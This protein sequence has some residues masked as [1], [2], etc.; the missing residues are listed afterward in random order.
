MKRIAAILSVL[1]VISLYYTLHFYRQTKVYNEDK[2]AR[3]KSDE[4]NIAGFDSTKKSRAAVYMQLK[5]DSTDIVFLGN[6]LTEAFPVTDYFQNIHVKNRGVGGYTT[7]E[8]LEFLPE[9]IK[10]HPRKIFIE[11]GIN[12]I[13]YGLSDKAKTETD[14]IDNYN[15]ILNAIQ[16]ESPKTE[17]FIQ[18]ILPI[19]KIY[20]A[21]ESDTINAIVKI[22]NPQIRD[23][24]LKYKYNVIDLY[25]QF[26]D[27]NS[28]PL[29]YTTDGIHLNA[30]GYA[31][32]YETI[33]NNVN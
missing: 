7:A 20:N 14:L 30:N 27:N 23:L 1:L 17:V 8:V 16:I 22:L 2:L 24:G 5:I 9:I 25:A 19:N 18:N 11:I 33:K 32:W 13:K 12:D 6:S 26:A 15:K 21:N 3:K 29:K 31:L 4:K 28:M 10:Y